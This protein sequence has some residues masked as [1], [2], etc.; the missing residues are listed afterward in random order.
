[1]VRNW[2]S[3]VLDCLGIHYEYC[4]T[5]CIISQAGI[6]FDTPELLYSLPDAILSYS[7]V[8]M[9][10]PTWGGVTAT[11]RNFADTQTRMQQQQLAE[12]FS[13]LAYRLVKFPRVLKY[14]KLNLSLSLRKIK[15]FWLLFEVAVGPFLILSQWRQ[16]PRIK[17][18]YFRR[19]QVW[20]KLPHVQE[21]HQAR[22]T[23][24]RGQISM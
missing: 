17:C 16:T 21:W 12:T 8:W 18:L 5:F 6:T 14:E 7:L 2:K 13:R 9:A 1:M 22:I 20:S 19:N 23:F 10:A 11:S 3:Q 15:L 4:K 24:L